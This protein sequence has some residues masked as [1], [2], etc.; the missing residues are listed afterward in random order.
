MRILRALRRI[1]RIL[2]P[3]GNRGSL[4]SSHRQPNGSGTQLPSEMGAAQHGH[5]VTF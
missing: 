3:P 1:L 2:T 4:E 5:D